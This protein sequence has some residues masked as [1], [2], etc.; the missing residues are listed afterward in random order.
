[1]NRFDRALF[2]AALVGAALFAGQLGAC[3]SG[4]TLAD[5]P[6]LD[7]DA[8]SAPD[9]ALPLCTAAGCADEQSLL[10]THAGRCSCPQADGGLVACE[11]APIVVIDGGRAKVDAP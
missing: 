4:C 5:D 3:L 1:M 8:Y 6:T 10:C 11:R 2:A 7:R 9:A